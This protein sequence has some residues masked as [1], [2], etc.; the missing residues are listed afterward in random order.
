[1][2]GHAGRVSFGTP[3]VPISNRRLR[4]Q[5]P[6]P[7]LIGLLLK[8][9]QLLLGYSKVAAQALEA[10]P[11]LSQSSFDHTSC[12]GADHSTS[13]FSPAGLGIGVGP[14]LPMV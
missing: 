3:A 13:R 5:R 6:N 11:D 8:V 1:M 9:G 7:R 2:P 10:V 4:N 12:H 14:H